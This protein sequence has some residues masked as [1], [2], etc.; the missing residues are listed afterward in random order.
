M[1]GN[2]V[3]S[4]FNLHPP[5]IDKYLHLEDDHTLH[6]D[7]DAQNPLPYTYDYGGNRIVYD[8]A[9]D[10]VLESIWITSEHIIK[11]WEI[12]INNDYKINIPTKT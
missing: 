7:D 11:T 12:N 9:E 3:S 4:M 2:S 6:T 8:S 10:I 1:N 5:S